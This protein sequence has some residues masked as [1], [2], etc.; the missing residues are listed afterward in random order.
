MTKQVLELPLPPVAKHM[1]STPAVL[2]GYSGNEGRNR[3]SP[4]A[5]ASSFRAATH[6]PATMSHSDMQFVT[7]EVNITA[8]AYLRLPVYTC[9]P[10]RTPGQC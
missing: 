9:P 4:V 7:L 3:A 6:G 5:F 2:L 1:L 8:S 10:P